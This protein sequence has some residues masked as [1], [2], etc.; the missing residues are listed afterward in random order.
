MT[1]LRLFSACAL[2]LVASGTA[3]AQDKALDKLQLKATPVRPGL[4]MLEGVNGFAGGNVGV[5]VGEDGVFIVDDELEKMSGKLVAA[6]AK[7][8]KQPVRFV[9][10][11]HWHGDH[12]GGNAALAKKGAIIVAHDNVRTRLNAAQAADRAK[13]KHSKSGAH[14]GLPVVTFAEDVSLHLNGDTVH[15]IHVP[16]AHTDGDALVHF[17]KANVIHAGDL[18]LSVGY[19]YVDLGSGGRFE[20]FIGAA[21]QILALSNDNTKIIPGHGTLVGKAEV[22]AWRDVLVTVRDRVGKLIAAGKTVKQAVAAKPTSD[23][24]AKVGSN[25][26]SADQI[27]EAAYKSMKADQKRKK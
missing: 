22:R 16:P 10:N 14:T 7:I 17:T 18:F 13:H 21:N 9:I 25:F 6:L 5:S 27:V 2:L 11:T 24:D 20:G 26:V 8:S 12:S 1:A 4:S 3:Q 23:L 19:P 15:L